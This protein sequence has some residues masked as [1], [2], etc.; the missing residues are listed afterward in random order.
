MLAR[1][2]PFRVSKTL[3]LESQ[4]EKYRKRCMQLINHKATYCHT[5][6]PNCMIKHIQ[7]CIQ[8]YISS[9]YHNNA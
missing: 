1:K 2:I 5:C 8:E 4:I 9:I 7:K 6:T 3:L